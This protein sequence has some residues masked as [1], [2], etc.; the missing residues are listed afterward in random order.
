MNEESLSKKGTGAAIFQTE[1]QFIVKSFTPDSVLTILL[2]VSN[3]TYIYEG[4]KL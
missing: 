3:L 4:F 2:A 1:R